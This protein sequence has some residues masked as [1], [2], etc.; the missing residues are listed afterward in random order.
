MEAGNANQNLLIQARA[1]GFET[2]T[3]GGIKDEE[4]SKALELPSDVRPIVLVT[5]GKKP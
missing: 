2:N 4:L 1:L 3:V 5:V